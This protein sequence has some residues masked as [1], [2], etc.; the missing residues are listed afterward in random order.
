MSNYSLKSNEFFFPK[1]TMFRIWNRC[2][3]IWCGWGSLTCSA[4]WC[5]FLLLDHWIEGNSD[6][7]EGQ[8]YTH[9]HHNGNVVF[10]QQGQPWWR[11][12]RY[13]VW[14]T[15]LNWNI[16]A[17]PSFTVSITPPHMSDLPLIIAG[18][19]WLGGVPLQPLCKLRGIGWFSLLTRF[20]SLAGIT[21][22]RGG[23][24]DAMD[25]RN[26]RL[27]G[28][29]NGWDWRLD[30]KGVSVLEWRAFRLR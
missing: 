12:L 25:D 5:R 24:V 23:R 27:R 14:N 1:F 21:L 9:S 22:Y 26:L 11:L 13:S 15:N 8:R 10:L 20:T 28:L 29:M 18:H 16:A 7:D 30:F 4:C 19:W 3:D 2:A 17:F 6:E